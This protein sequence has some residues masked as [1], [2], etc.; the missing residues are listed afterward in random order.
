MKLIFAT[1]F[2]TLSFLP[3]LIYAQVMSSGSYR[4][5]SDSINF[6]GGLSSSTNYVVSDTLG[7]VGTGFSSSTSYA[8]NSGYQFMQQVYI[9]ITDSADLSLPNVGGISGGSSSGQSTWTVTTDDP[10]GYSLLVS[11]LTSPALKST[12]TSISDYSPSSAIPDFTFVVGSAS[13]TFGFSPEGI[14]IISRFKDNGSNCNTGTSDTIDRCWDGF[15]TTPAIIAQSSGSNHP[16]GATTT[17]KYNV[18]IGGN[19]IQEAGNYSASITVTA[20]AL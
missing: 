20:V 10:G 11:A 18:G 17:I 9:A 7:E 15:S 2:I 1:F 3:I 5:Q 13:S 6:G 12:S 4:I 19:K 16:N 14:D 8:L